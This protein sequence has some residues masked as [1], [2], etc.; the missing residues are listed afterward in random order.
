MFNTTHIHNT[1][2]RL[3]P[4]E[5]TVTV[6]EHRAPTD[7]SVELLNEFT[8]KAKQNIIDTIHIKNNVIECVVVYYSDDLLKDRIN[9]WL[10]FKLNDK[11]YKLNGDIEKTEL[12]EVHSAHGLRVQKVF[13]LLVKKYSEIIAIEILK[14]TPQSHQIFS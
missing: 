5:K 7:H 3:V 11:E 13:D 14:Q 12:M 8:E 6:T 9:F 10:R 1:K 2:D 4:Y